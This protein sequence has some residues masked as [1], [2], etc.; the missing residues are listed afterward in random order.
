MSSRKRI[1]SLVLHGVHIRPL[2]QRFI[3]HNEYE[4]A[5]HVFYEPLIRK[6]VTLQIWALYII[7]GDG[8]KV[9]DR[10]RYFFTA[11]E[12]GTQIDITS[13]TRFSRAYRAN[14]DRK[15]WIDCYFTKDTEMSKFIN[16]C[17]I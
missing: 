11:Y 3:R 17:T 1:D 6:S 7:S 13:D 14:F 10:F 9:D 4:T 2:S 5:D 16:E 15:P 8:A 12:R